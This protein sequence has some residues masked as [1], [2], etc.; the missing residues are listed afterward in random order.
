MAQQ[1]LAAGRSADTASTAGTGSVRVTPVSGRALL[2]R[3]IT[4]PEK[5]YADD[6]SWV[7]PLRLERKLHFDPRH[8]PFFQQAEAQLWLAERNGQTVGRISAQINQVHLRR[9]EDATGHFGFLEAEDDPEVFARLFDT[10]ETWLR[11][12]GL[13]QVMGPFSL[14][15]NDESGLLIDGF[16]TPPSVMMGHG[17]PWYGERVEQCGYRKA[18]DLIAYAYDV[19]SEP[20]PV[21]RAFSAKCA[22]QSGLRFRFMDM[23]K[24][25]D[26][27]A[28]V[29]TI[30]NDA[31][32]DNWGFLPFSHAEMQH[33]AHMLKPL[34]QSEDVAIGEVD[35][36]P[37]A[38]VV[39]LPNINEAI[40]DLNGR[41]LPFG[42]VKAL[43]RLKV[44]GVKTA[45]IPLM[46]VLRRYHGSVLSIMLAHGVIEQIR[47]S[48][49]RKGF[50]SAEL[51]WILED[52]TS[53]RRI[54]EK[55]GGR[56]YKTYRI[57]AKDLA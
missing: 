29:V 23:T 44:V 5:L 14:S 25:K 18:K 37:A 16:G 2:K 10:A 21:V 19:E 8:N 1:A 6:P 57:F 27:I 32:A 53:I 17:R 4:F 36:V 34:L 35:G 7:A 39:C 15:I 46:G 45:R 48:H 52:N 43:W 50:R 55:W 9:Y 40:A 41:L 22:G 30:F 51:S 20:P 26:E 12:R 24:F 47:V 13:R 38:V 31:W 56:A 33:L 28:L 3:F 42:W 11:S 49:Q 54:I